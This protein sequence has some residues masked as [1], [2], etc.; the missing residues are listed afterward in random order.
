M[1][2]C[3]LPRPCSPAS[4]A[5]PGALTTWAASL[6]LLNKYFELSPSQEA[7][8]GGTA[9]GALVTPGLTGARGEE[10]RGS[11]T[12][13][14]PPTSPPAHHSLTLTAPLTATVLSN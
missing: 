2:S 12:P 14:L 5:G 9:R 10:P 11:Q 6:F 13:S 7:G 4:P 8:G 3:I 1:W